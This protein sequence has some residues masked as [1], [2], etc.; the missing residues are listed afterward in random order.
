MARVRCAGG[1]ASCVRV[2]WRY[3]PGRGGGGG[4]ATYMG[5][6]CVWVR[7][8]SVP[9]HGTRPTPSR[10]K[11][12]PGPGGGPRPLS[13]S[14]VDLRASR[15]WSVQ[16]MWGERVGAGAHLFVRARRMEA[17]AVHPAG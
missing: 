14:P 10:G 17:Y 15:V 7:C 5:R 12:P 3:T 9:G 4:G 8:S 6:V 11:T 13:V 16:G 2:G 1:A